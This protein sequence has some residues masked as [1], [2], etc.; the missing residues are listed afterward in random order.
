M[1]R[2]V[3]VPSPLARF[4]IT[5]PQAQPLAFS[6]N[7]RDIAIAPDGTR[8]VYTAGDQAQLMVRSLDRLDAAPLAGLVN[9]RAPFFRLTPGGSASSNAS[10]KG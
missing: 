8:L 6:I 2:P 3:P 7:D 10:T 1:T 5:L 9:T 4:A